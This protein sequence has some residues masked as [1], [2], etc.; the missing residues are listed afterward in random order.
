MARTK[1]RLQI[2][3]EGLNNTLSDVEKARLL[4]VI[5]VIEDTKDLSRA[6]KAQA[7][8]GNIFTSNVFIALSELLF[9]AYAQIP[10][11]TEEAEKSETRT[12]AE[13]LQ[14]LLG[15]KDKER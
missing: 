1:T 3:A 2:A 8:K 7:L 5:A 14:I 10:Q 15:D 4:D 12:I 9:K 13:A 11:G 6:A